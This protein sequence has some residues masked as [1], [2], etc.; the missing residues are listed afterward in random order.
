[1][2]MKRAEAAGMA[3]GAVADGVFADPRRGHPVA[4]FG[5]AVSRVE[6]AVYA[7]DRRVGA[8]FAAGAIA[9]AA[10]AGAAMRRAGA[11]G[12]AAAAFTALGGTSLCRIGDQ[13][14]DALEAGDIDGA[15]TL[16]AGLVGRD[17]DLLDESGICR[18]AVE[19][20]AE[21]TSDAA[22][23]P[24]VFGAAA[25]ATG[26]LAYRA[27]N[28]LDAMIGYRS[29][30][31]RNFGWAAARTDDLANLVPAR[32]T[33]LLAA[34]VSGRPRAVWT[35]VRRDAHRHPSPNAGVVEAAFA[36]AL[37][38]ELGGRTVYAHGVEERPRLGDGRAPTVADLRG[39]VEL[40]RR[41]Q[42]AAAT[43]AVLTR[44]RAASTGRRRY[45]P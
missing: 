15:R 12:T 45:F 23:G 16:V 32:L 26:M 7:D 41:I 9:A 11:A 24:L 25:G 17:P 10:A 31:Y 2:R 21:N 8:V 36:G 37:D 18:A 38:I 34:G 43:F 40:S 13:I 4:G 1:M 6:Q 20:I 44:Y 42:V 29:E 3:L 14:A 19:S 39:A 35:A 22:V 33:A 28:T 5:T 27:I 30:R